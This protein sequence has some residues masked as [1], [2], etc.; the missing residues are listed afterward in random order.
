MTEKGKNCDIPCLAALP[1]GRLR[2]GYS[3]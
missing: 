1:F 3:E 2:A